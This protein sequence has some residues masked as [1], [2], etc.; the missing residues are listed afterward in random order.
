MVEES[1]VMVLL[2]EKTHPGDGGGE[3]GHGLA[4]GNVL[5][6]LQ[7]GEED[8]ESHGAVVLHL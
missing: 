6:E 2:K 1:W 8:S 7:P 5:E 3:L 4:E